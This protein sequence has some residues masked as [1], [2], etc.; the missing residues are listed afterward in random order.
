MRKLFAAGTLGL[1]ALAACSDDNGTEPIA[2][3]RVRVVHAVSNVA[4]ADVLFGSDT[5]KAG[6]AYKGVY[7]SATVPAGKATVKVRK[8][9][10]T[11]DLVKV[12][13]DVA[14]GKSYSIVAFGSEAAP[15]SLALVDDVSAPASGKAKVRVAHAAAGQ[16]AVDVYLLAKAA[17]LATA[18]AAKTNLAAKSA[19][20]YVVKDAGTYVVIL[21]ETGKKDVV[22]TMEGVKLDAGKVLT[23]VAIEKAGGGAPI[24]S[25]TLTD[26]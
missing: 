5:K 15:Q 1:L 16:A 4:T 18:T 26:R 3:G 19:S 24:E 20:D 23:I 6:L 13:Q 14:S 7:E 11:A 25:I 22:L 2:Q 17:D 10:A 8:A 21:T 9:G 12:E